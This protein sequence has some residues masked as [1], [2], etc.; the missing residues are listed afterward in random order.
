MP[1]PRS[2]PRS[3]LT[4]ETMTMQKTR[5]KDGETVWCGTS[6]CGA[7]L[8]R[9]DGGDPPLFNPGWG[10]DYDEAEGAWRPTRHAK[11]GWDAARARVTRGLGTPAEIERV[12]AGPSAFARPGYK[13]QEPDLGDAPDPEDA[14]GVIPTVWQATMDA[15]PPVPPAFIRRVKGGELPARIRCHKCKR[16]GEVVAP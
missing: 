15:W 4:N 5:I 13:G 12:K 6:G 1:T 3:T 8:G 7:P 9:L 11:R 16:L 10:W 14:P 2:T